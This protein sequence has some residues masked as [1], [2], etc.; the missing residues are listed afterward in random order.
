[1]QIKFEALDST[2]KA[3]FNNLAKVANFGYLD[4]ETALALQIGHR[5]SYDFDIFCKEEIGNKLIKRVQEIFP[6]REVLI[7][8]GDEFSFITQDNVKFSFIYY[9]FDLSRF[10]IEEKNMPINILS[11][12]GIAFAKAYTLN[13]RA[14]WRDYLDLYFIFKKRLISLKEVVKKS[15]EIYGEIFNEKLFYAQLLYTDDISDGE[16]EATEMI[17]NKVERGEVEIFFQKIIK[18]EMKSD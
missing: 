16:I 5:K 1:M 4:G 14:G 12:E 3:Y 15:K 2:R 18:E 17:K 11:P 9:P 6:I 7:R 8:N 13:R 10:V